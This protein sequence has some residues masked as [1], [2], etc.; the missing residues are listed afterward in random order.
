MNGSKEFSERLDY[1]L[2]MKLLISPR[3][4][5]TPL[6]STTLLPQSKTISIRGCSFMLISNSGE[7]IIR[8]ICLALEWQSDINVFDILTQF[9]HVGFNRG[10]L[11]NSLGDQWQSMFVEVR[12]FVQQPEWMRC[13]LT[14]ALVRLQTL[15][16]CLRQWRKSGIFFVK[17]GLD[18]MMAPPFPFSYPKIGSSESFAI[19]GVNTCDFFAIAKTR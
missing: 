10:P 11:K 14:A 8:R 15:N 6:P 13:I 7:A 4:E 16:L 19:F 12:E 2:R 5:R 1:T 9:E 17:M 18:S 3:T